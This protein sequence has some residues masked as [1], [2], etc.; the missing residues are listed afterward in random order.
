MIPPNGRLCY[1]FE[2]LDGVSCNFRWTAKVS[3]IERLAEVSFIGRLK[4]KDTI[5]RLQS[6][7]ARISRQN[8]ILLIYIDSRRDRNL[9]FY[10]ALPIV[11]KNQTYFI[12]EISS[13]KRLIYSTLMIFLRRSVMSSYCWISGLATRLLLLIVVFASAHSDDSNSGKIIY[14]L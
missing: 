2:N 11:F 10:L 13:N 5:G 8:R 4:H 1:F 12:A 7:I 6:A 9:R 14:R 3:F